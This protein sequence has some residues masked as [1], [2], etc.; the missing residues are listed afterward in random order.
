MPLYVFARLCPSFALPS[1]DTLCIAKILMG[2]SF[3]DHPVV[4]CCLSFKI[5]KDNP[6]H[7]YEI[8]MTETSWPSCLKGLPSQTNFEISL[9]HCSKRLEGTMMSVPWQEKFS[10]QLGNTKTSE[11]MGTKNRRND[12]YWQHKQESLHV[13][14]TC[15]TWVTLVLETSN[16]ANIFSFGSKWSTHRPVVPTLAGIKWPRSSGGTDGKGSLNVRSIKAMVVAWQSSQGIKGRKKSTTTCKLPTSQTTKRKN[17]LG[18]W[19]TNQ[20][21]NWLTN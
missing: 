8:H 21:T 17:K 2:Q 4:M 14:L 13:S 10:G 18:N 5:F 7:P 12:N 15:V 11:L 6:W 3:P 1:G 9:S 16:I 20:P 19:L